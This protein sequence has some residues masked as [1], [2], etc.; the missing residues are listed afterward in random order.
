MSD[1]GVRLRGGAALALGKVLAVGRNYADHAAEMKAPA[2]P[3]IFMKPPTA[4]RGPG[5]P[6]ELPRDRGAV[7]H[8]LEVVVWLAAGG[9]RL[10]ETEA[11]ACVGA[12][13]LGLDLT[14]RD[15]QDRAKEKR[16]PWTL[17]KGFDASL[18]LSEFVPASE[19]P[20][21]HALDMR[22]LVNGSLR[23]QTSTSLMLLTVPR[24]LAYISSWITLQPGDLVLTGTPAG[25]GP[26]LPGDEA[27]MILE[28]YLE[29]PVR[30]L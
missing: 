14:L 4:V 9:S 12:Y 18:P 5:I 29:Q 2:E 15:V 11:E 3:V 19:I 21:P 25:V 24:L 16:Q 28:G 10:D 20:D 13:G 6:V 27:V 22:L 17:A 1:S 23:Q 30:F 8:E 26:V 7:H